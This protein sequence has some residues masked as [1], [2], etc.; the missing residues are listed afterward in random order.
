MNQDHDQSSRISVAALGGAP[1][2]GET[3]ADLPK[4][5][6]VLDQGEHVRRI[7]PL[8]SELRLEGVARKKTTCSAHSELQQLCTLCG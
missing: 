3:K 7:L 8:A 1:H 2:T 5:R 4:V 6:S